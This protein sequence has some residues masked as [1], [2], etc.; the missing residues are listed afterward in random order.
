M[1]KTKVKCDLNTFLCSGELMKRYSGKKSG[2]LLHTT[3]ELEVHETRTTRV[4]LRIGEA[5]P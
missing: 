3:R 1:P 2:D 4:E 5:R